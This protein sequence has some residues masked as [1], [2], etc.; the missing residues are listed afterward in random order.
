V[1]S[2]RE[3]ALAFSP[4]RH[5]AFREAATRKI[6]SAKI[7]FFDLNLFTTHDKSESQ[8]NLLPKLE[9]LEVDNISWF[10][11]E[12]ILR[13]LTNRMAA[14]SRGD[15]SPLRGLKLHMSRQMQRD[16]REEAFARAKAAGFE[17]RLELDYLV[18]HPPYNGRLL[19]PFSFPA[20]I[21]PDE[22]WPPVFDFLDG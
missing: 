1:P 11:D 19:P 6:Y 13:L 17:V 18:N 8:N 4:Q 7:S 3:P 12:D 2:P 16:I 9:V 21:S 22:I 20:W 15:V 14:A 5:S 10:T